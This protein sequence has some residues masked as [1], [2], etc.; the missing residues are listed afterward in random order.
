ML[1]FLRWQMCWFMAGRVLVRF[2]RAAID[3]SDHEQIICLQGE[4]SFVR[5]VWKIVYVIDFSHLLVQYDA[6]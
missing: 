1:F 2:L 3:S 6:K 5:S 4:I